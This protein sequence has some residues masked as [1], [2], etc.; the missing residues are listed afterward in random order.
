MK[1]GGRLGL[2]QEL[3]LVSSVTLK[4]QKAREIS[5]RRHPFELED[6]PQRVASPLLCPFGE[7][8]VILCDSKHYRFIMCVRHL[9]G[10]R[11]S[12]LASPNF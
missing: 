9:R 7:R 10:N 11:A 4:E 1:H 6:K 3:R 5:L 2:P 8:F 12:F